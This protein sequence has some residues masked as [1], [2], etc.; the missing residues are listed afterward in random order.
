MSYEDADIR[1]GSTDSVDDDD[2]VLELAKMEYRSQYYDSD[3]PSPLFGRREIVYNMP[4]PLSIVRPPSVES[5]NNFNQVRFHKATL[6][7][8]V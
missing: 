7:S 3:V 2:E 4:S 8:S 1:R 5:R 6:Q